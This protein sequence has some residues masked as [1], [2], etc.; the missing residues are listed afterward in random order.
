MTPNLININLSW[1]ERIDCFFKNISNHH[2]CSDI[3]RASI[4]KIR[5]DKL[6]VP[7]NTLYE[8]YLL[9]NKLKIVEPIPIW[10]FLISSTIVYPDPKSIPR[11]ANLDIRVKNLKSKFENNLYNKMTRDVG[12]PLHLSDTKLFKSNFFH[13]R[14]ANKQLM[15]ILNFLIIIICTF[16]FGFYVSDIIFNEHGIS[17]FTRLVCGLI[18]SIVA[19]IADLYFLLRNINN[20][21]ELY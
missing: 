2:S 11:D 8:C 6:T 17:F 5:N 20:L 13:I 1:N 4:L 7:F 3:L 15:M 12:S 19:F 16:V 21:E 18:C 9:N 14:L 10:R